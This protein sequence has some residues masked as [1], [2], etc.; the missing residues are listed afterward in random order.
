MSGSICLIENRRLIHICTYVHTSVNR[1]I[2]NSWGKQ[3]GINGY[4]KVP[5]GKGQCGVSQIEE[6]GYYAVGGTAYVNGTTIFSQDDLAND[7]NGNFLSRLLQWKYLTV[8]IAIAIAF[9]AFPILM[10]CCH[11]LYRCCCPG[12]GGSPR[13]QRARPQAVV[14]PAATGAGGGRSPGG[15]R[16]SPH[17]GGYPGSRSPPA[18]GKRAQSPP[19]GGGGG[20]SPRAAGGAASPTGA[21]ASSSEWSCSACTFMNPPHK[22]LCQICGQYRLA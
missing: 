8:V 2:K 18:G 21:G 4:G 5:R 19:V 15:G 6:Y 11:S 13:D 1:L 20:H 12:A 17:H 7:P 16:R 22:K 3:W 14:V 9:L 10:S